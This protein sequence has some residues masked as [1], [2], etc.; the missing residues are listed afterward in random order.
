MVNVCEDL[1]RVSGGAF[2]CWR[3]SL[4]LQKLIW[5][6]H[7]HPHLM[8][9]RMSARYQYATVDYC[10]YYVQRS[11]LDRIWGVLLEPAFALLGL[12]SLVISIVLP[13]QGL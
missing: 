7:P 8:A 4:V 5:I 9:A 3:R 11:L 12:R 2:R 1:C 13:K 10:S 6:C